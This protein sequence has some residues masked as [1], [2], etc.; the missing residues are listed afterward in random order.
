M[1][2]E[3]DL[4]KLY[5]LEV[6]NIIECKILN[7]NIEIDN[8]FIE[9]I[10]NILIF[11]Y[12]VLVQFLSIFYNLNENQVYFGNR[13]IDNKN[14][15]VINLL[16]YECIANQ[17]QLKK[18][19]LLYDTI[20]DDILEKVENYDIKEEIEQNLLEYLNEVDLDK[21]VNYNYY[22]DVDVSKII[23]NYIYIK[24]DL[25]LEKYS[26]IIKILINNLKNKNIKKNIII[27]IN[28]NIFENILDDIENIYIFKFYNKNE[29]PNILIGNQ[30]INLDKE[31]MINQLIINWPTVISYEEVS[32]YLTMFCEDF[33]VNSMLKIDNYKKITAYKILEKV[34]NIPL[35]IQYI[36][37][38]QNIPK[39]Y[40]SFIKN[41]I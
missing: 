39:L 38:E 34:L 40:F 14:T 22:F 23:S 35:N 13:K 37:D 27:F 28:N 17:L 12:K 6:N 7:N 3:L 41:L 19:T 5:F 24:M 36:L 30:I 11:N 15:I 16:D 8:L 9:N 21:K 32:V 20:L 10:N 4:R 1:N 25:N 26:K 33:Q 18:G 29:F 2:L 31:L